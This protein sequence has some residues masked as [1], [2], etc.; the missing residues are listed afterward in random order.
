MSKVREGRVKTRRSNEPKKL[1]YFG[2]ARPVID[3]VDIQCEVQERSRNWMLVNL[4]ELGLA[5]NDKKQP[6]K[7]EKFLRRHQDDDHVTVFMRVSERMIKQLDRI[8]KKEDRPRAAIL[9]R[10]VMCQLSLALPKA[11]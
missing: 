10:L 11:A 6:K 5:A 7:V 4:T 9:R 8:A 2:L 3:L 1:I